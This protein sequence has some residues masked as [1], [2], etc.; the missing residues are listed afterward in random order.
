[1]L[2]KGGLEGFY[3]RYFPVPK[4]GGNNKCPILDLHINMY[5]MRYEFC[6]LTHATLICMVLSADWFTS[7]DLKDIPIYP[8]H[9]KFL[10]FAFQDM[11]YKHLVLSFGLSQICEMCWDSY[12]SPQG[13]KY[14]DT[15]RYTLACFVLTKQVTYG[16]RLQGA[17]LVVGMGRLYMRDFQRWVASL[18]LDPKRHRAHKFAVS[19]SWALAEIAVFPEVWVW[20]QYHPEKY[21]QWMPA[22]WAFRKVDQLFLSWAQPS[23]NKDFLIG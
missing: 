21:W 7:I 23:P 13:A 3:S 1:M 6:M 8:P 5:L 14:P 22:C 9:R 4:K 12:S 15:F 16:L 19:A 18:R 20:E 10:R 11:M 17:L 2:H